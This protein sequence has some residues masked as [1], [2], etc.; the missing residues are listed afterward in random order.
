MMQLWILRQVYQQE[1]SPLGFVLVEPS[2]TSWLYTKA[3]VSHAMYTSLAI[4]NIKEMQ[5]KRK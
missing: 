2:V 3:I 1:P 4:Y 5:L